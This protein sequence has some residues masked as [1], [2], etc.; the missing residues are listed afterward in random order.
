M[1]NK[2]ISIII[3]MIIIVIIGICAFLVIYM[4]NKKNSGTEKYS[5]Q[6]DIVIKGTK[7][8]PIKLEDFEVTNIDI[9]KK[10]E[11]SLEV[12]AT[13]V[14]KSDIQVKGFYIE[15]GLF[16]EE[17][18]KV[19]EVAKKYI[20]DINPKEKYNLK[21]SIVGLKNASEITSAKILRIDKDIKTGM[22]EILNTNNIK[23][24][25]QGN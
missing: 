22:Q 6:P 3:F 20:E 9:F 8:N 2:K 7:E 21:A 25:S 16:D 14:N 11:T 17:G 1:K 5:R 24:D 19:T 10:T 13:V 12:N 23:T 4:N 18:K 15:I